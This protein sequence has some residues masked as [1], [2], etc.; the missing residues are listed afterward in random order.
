VISNFLY[1]DFD[2]LDHHP[3]LLCHSCLFHHHCVPLFPVKRS[4]RVLTRLQSSHSH[5]SPCT[6]LFLN[7]LQDQHQRL[8]IE[9]KM[10]L[11]FEIPTHQYDSCSW[12]S[13]SSRVHHLQSLL[14]QV[15]SLCPEDLSGLGS[16]L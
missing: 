9:L 3:C 6:D 7:L 1:S 15:L 16:F 2:F 11:L 13:Q 12:I 14:G 8:E 4:F 5:I 10:H